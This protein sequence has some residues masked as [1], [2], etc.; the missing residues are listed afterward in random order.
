MLPVVSSVAL[1]YHRVLTHMAIVEV[2]NLVKMFEGNNVPA[3]NNINIRTADGEFLVLLGPSGCGKSTLLRML[4]GLEKPT[5]GEILIGD[6]VVFDSPEYGVAPGQ[7]TVLY[8]GD[9]VLGG[10]WI[11]STEAALAAA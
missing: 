5:S 9:R 2:R 7:A 6:R 1:V 8:A 3:V 4:G 11:A 10:G